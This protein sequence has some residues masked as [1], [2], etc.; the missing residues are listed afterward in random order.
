MM[1]LLS[2]N[3]FSALNTAGADIA[4]ADRS[5]DIDFDS[6][7]IRKEATKAFSDDLGTRTTG[8]FDLTASFIFIS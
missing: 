5:I 6:L 1:R 2:L 3:D 7:Q 8:S 4:A